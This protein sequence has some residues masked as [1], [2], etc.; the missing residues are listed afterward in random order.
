MPRIQ[1]VSL[2]SVITA[3]VPIA[4]YSTCK[5]QCWLQY[6]VSKHCTGF[7]MGEE[8]QCQGEGGGYRAEYAAALPSWMMHAQHTLQAV[9]V[10]A[11]QGIDNS[12]DKEFLAFWAEARGVVLINVAPFSFQDTLD[13]AGK[14]GGITGAFTR[15]D[16]P[17]FVEEHKL[18]D[19]PRVCSPEVLYTDS[20]VVFLNHISQKD[21]QVCT[22]II[23]RAYF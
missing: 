11:W 9:L 22:V 7:Y 16:I 17:H 13:A 2:L 15:L 14:T 6:L 19:L 23:P 3:V 18:L 1:C 8:S 10:L 12:T 4:A 21:M 20:D 5:V